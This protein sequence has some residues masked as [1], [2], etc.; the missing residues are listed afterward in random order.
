MPDQV[1]VVTGAT[2]RIGGEISMRFGEGENRLGLL[3]NKNH[4]LINYYLC[5]DVYYVNSEDYRYFPFA[6]M[7]NMHYDS[8]IENVKYRYNE[9][10]RTVSTLNCM[11][12]VF[13][14]IHLPTEAIASKGRILNILISQDLSE[15]IQFSNSGILYC[16]QRC[17]EIDS[18]VK[19]SND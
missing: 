13:Y 5:F 19:L 18:I 10:V 11:Y 16:R 1:I 12:F 9:L 8:K 6:E 2:G 7:M 3:Y 15:Q 4:E 14:I 17:F